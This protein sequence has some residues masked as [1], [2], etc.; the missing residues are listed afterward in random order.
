MPLTDWTDPTPGTLYGIW[1][2]DQNAILDKIRTGMQ[3]QELAYGKL[4]VD[5]ATAIAAKMPGTAG[6]TRLVLHAN[7]DQG[8]LLV[9]GA[10]D[11]GIID[12]VLVT[13][14]AG[15]P[16]CWIKNAGGLGL[17]DWLS[18][19]RDLF[20][21]PTWQA[22]IYGHVRRNGS[23]E[24]CWPG[25][26]GNMLPWVDAM[27]ELYESTRSGTTGSWTA[28][29]GTLALFTETP[30]ATPPTRSFSSNRLTASSSALTA[31]TATGTAGVP[32]TAGSVY[33]PIA[34][35]RAEDVADN[36]QV[37]FSWYNGAAFISTVYGSASATTVGSWVRFTGGGLTAPVGTTRAA[38]AVQVPSTASGRHFRVA[39]GG[40]FPGTQTAWGPPFVGNGTYGV[41]GQAAVGDR[42]K[43]T[44]DPTQGIE[45]VCLTGGLPYQQVWASAI[46]IPSSSTPAATAASGAAG[47]ASDMSRSDHVHAS[48]QL[49]STAAV[50]LGSAA[51]GSAT[52]SSRQDH[53]HP[54]TGVVAN[55]A[56]TAKGAI[57]TASAAS[58]PAALAV[59][60]NGQTLIADST[61]TTGQKWGSPIDIQTFTAGGG[62]TWTKP[63]GATLVQYKLVG[64]G[65]GGGA[66]RRGAAGSGR[67]GGAGG[68]GGS[69]TEGWVAASALSATE[70]VAVGTGGAGAAGQT[71]NDTDGATG[72]G[73]G[74][75]SFKST[76]FAFAG[77]GNGGTG[78][79]ATAGAAV[80]GGAGQW[81]GGTSAAGATTVGT[82]P[83]S[84]PSYAPP[85]GGSGGGITTGN[86][87]SA[88]G[89]GGQTFSILGASGGAAGTSG[90]GT[91]GAGTSQAVG[92]PG[93]GT[94]GGGGGSSGGSGGAGGLYGAGGGGGAA[95][96]NATTSGA[97]GAGANGIVQIVSY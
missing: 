9:K 59:G 15:A 97:G 75:S 55:S 95:S 2:A 33:T 91:G 6:V 31:Q 21:S 93:P 64:G 69:I 28:T 73:G 76:S 4:I 30:G 58:T 48:P 81:Q 92:V 18:V 19:F 22:D 63:A 74:A 44:D 32:V 8:A 36:A 53:V 51:A 89:G 77:G 72:T 11:T 88:G 35:V 10:A 45:Y 61:Q 79:T 29:G 17:N 24:F 41:F 86:A 16:I 65:A 14:F 25:P 12:M 37:G 87:N 20:N 60:S 68:G 49:S 40:I 5:D 42:W 27:G 23:A 47:A 84:P 83:T 34:Y 66:G 3:A 71:V 82:A 52:S 94:G 54:T 50:A 1:G 70:T 43:R 80:F 13:D 39:A 96:L 7:P 38:V 26:P 57:L 90:G 56:L 85:G 78:G 62:T 67:A 46:P